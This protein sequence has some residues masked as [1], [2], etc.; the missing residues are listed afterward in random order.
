MWSM[1]QRE[2][3]CIFLPLENIR[4]ETYWLC[5][6]IISNGLETKCNKIPKCL[7]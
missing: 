5:F 2:K 3:N 7:F 1:R 6:T 4:A